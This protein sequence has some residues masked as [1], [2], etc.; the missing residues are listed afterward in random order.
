MEAVELRQRKVQHGQL[1]DLPVM[2]AT[3]ATVPSVPRGSSL[4]LQ[5]WPGLVPPH[6]RDH[7]TTRHLDK[8][9]YLG[10]IPI[11]HFKIMRFQKSFK[12][13]CMNTMVDNPPHVIPSAFALCSRTRQFGCLLTRLL[14]KTTATITPK[15]QEKQGIE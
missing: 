9:K 7:W 8:I 1:P 14:T 4:R 11:P 15:E 13:W 5:I 6:Q 3:L 10:L 2:S 12:E